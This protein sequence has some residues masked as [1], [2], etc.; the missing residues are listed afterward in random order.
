VRG[1]LTHGQLNALA[2]RLARHAVLCDVK[3][4]TLLGLFLDRSNEL[5]IAILAILK[6]GG[7]EADG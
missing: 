1:T 4:D 6:A 2:N 5:V 3:A 7:M